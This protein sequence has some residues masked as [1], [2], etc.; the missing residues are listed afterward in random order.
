MEYRQESEVQS[1]I[2]ELVVM[3]ARIQKLL[4]QAR[5]GINII[6][7]RKVTLS[8]LLPVGLTGLWHLCYCLLYQT[9]SI[10]FN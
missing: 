3:K 4:T 5:D 10:Y 7:V 8:T 1:L 6:Q 2:K 9:E